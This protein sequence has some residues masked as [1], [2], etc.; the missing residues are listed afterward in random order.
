VLVLVLVLVLVPMVTVVTQ[1]WTVVGCDSLILMRS[2]SSSLR[3]QH[4]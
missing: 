1:A 2:S 3:A 4:Q